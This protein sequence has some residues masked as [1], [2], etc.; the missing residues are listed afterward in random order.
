MTEYLLILD[1]V[2]KN[3]EYRQYCLNYLRGL[4]RR[5]LEQSTELRADMTDAEIMKLIAET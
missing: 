5:G 1:P 3:A 2:Y 4:A